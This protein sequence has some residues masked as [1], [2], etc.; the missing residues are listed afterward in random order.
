M[1]RVPVQF[2][3]EEK[4]VVIDKDGGYEPDTNSH[5]IDWHFEGLDTEQHAALNMTDDEEQAVFEQIVE[6]W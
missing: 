1:R 5:D 4:I 2:R 3:G 6:D